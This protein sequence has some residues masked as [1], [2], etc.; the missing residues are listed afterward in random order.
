[1]LRQFQPTV[2]KETVMLGRYP[3]RNQ[4]LSQFI[5]NKTGEQRTA[6]QVGSRLQQLRDSCPGQDCTLILYS[7]LF[8]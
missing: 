3:G 4:F 6:K 1:G 8:L 2:C 5:L 7:L